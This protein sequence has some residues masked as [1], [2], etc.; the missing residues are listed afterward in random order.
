MQSPGQLEARVVGPGR[1]PAVRLRHAPARHCRLVPT[2]RNIYSIKTFNFKPG[3]GPVFGP[4]CDTYIPRSRYQG[5]SMDRGQFFRSRGVAVSTGSGWEYDQDFALQVS[6]G[7]AFAREHFFGNG[8]EQ[9]EDGSP[10]WQ[11]NWKAYAMEHF[12]P[13]WVSSQAMLPLLVISRSFPERLLVITAASGAAGPRAARRARRQRFAG[14][15]RSAVR[16]SAAL[17]RLV[18]PPIRA[19]AAAAQRH[20]YRRDPLTGLRSA[21]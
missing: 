10:V 3:F 18:L 7:E 9:E 19:V 8:I 12:A 13:R 21:F 14:Q 20:C 17:E 6:G 4:I 2:P 1:C 15:H 11:S 5:L 16:V